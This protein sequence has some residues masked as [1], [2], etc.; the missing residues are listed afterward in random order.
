MNKPTKK[1][2]ALTI[3]V[4]VF[5]VGFGAV[6]GAV[7]TSIRYDDHLREAAL[8]VGTCRELAQAA[9]LRYSQ[10]MLGMRVELEEL[11]ERGRCIGL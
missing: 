3:A 7:G 2:I 8:S 10:T 5:L 11:K 1:D 4:L 9:Y 6:G